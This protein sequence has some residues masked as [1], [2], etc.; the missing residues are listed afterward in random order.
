M[1]PLII[2]KLAEIIKAQTISGSTGP[3]T[4]TPIVLCRKLKINRFN[5]YLVKKR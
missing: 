5:R 4:P 2:S 3:F 1:K